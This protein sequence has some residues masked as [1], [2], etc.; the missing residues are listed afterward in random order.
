V[1]S[2]FRR[3]YTEV[4]SLLYVLTAVLSIT[5]MILLLRR[6]EPAAETYR[7]YPAKHKHLYDSVFFL[8]QSIYA[9]RSCCSL[10]SKV[11]DI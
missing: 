9:A 2:S 4:G 8:G 3:P 11:S 7:S 5:R 1:S 10:S 6:L